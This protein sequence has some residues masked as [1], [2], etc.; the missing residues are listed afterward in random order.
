MPPC[1]QAGRAT[2]ERPQS[3]RSTWN[4]KAR[5]SREPAP[6]RKNLQAQP[7]EERWPLDNCRCDKIQVFVVPDEAEAS[8]SKTHRTVAVSTLGPFLGAGFVSP[9]IPERPT[10]C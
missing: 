5:Y 1:R 9:Q 6:P 8:D 3:R 7:S 2:E 10:S 4:D